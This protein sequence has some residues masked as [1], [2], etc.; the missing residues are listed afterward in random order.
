MGT[1][2]PVVDDGH[3]GRKERIQPLGH[4]CRSLVDEAVGAGE[5]L[6]TNASTRSTSRAVTHLVGQP[7]HPQERRSDV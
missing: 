4:V 1:R 2:Q 7:V 5:A 3:A 6:A